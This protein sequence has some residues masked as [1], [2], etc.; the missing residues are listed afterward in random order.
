MNK[1]NKRYLNK[2]SFT[3]EIKNKFPVFAEVERISIEEWERENSQV[4]LFTTKPSERPF[5]INIANKEFVLS[6]VQLSEIYDCL[7]RRD[8]DDQWLRNHDYTILL[9]L[10]TISQLKDNAPAK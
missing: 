4:N 5:H 6:D 2:L 3:E 9:L 1:E 8:H 10:M 7:L